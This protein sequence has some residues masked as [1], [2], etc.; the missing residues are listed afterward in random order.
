MRNNRHKNFDNRKP[1][2]PQPRGNK[3]VVIDGNVEQAIRKLKKKVQNSG[4]LDD[5]REK[6]YYIK[7]TQKRKMAKQMAIKRT[8]KKAQ[9]EELRH[10]SGKKY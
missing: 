10:R 2:I 4:L 3:V 6:E 7:P 1:F 5:L 8:K 9:Q